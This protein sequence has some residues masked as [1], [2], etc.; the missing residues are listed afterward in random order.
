MAVGSR[1]WAVYVA[2]DHGARF[3]SPEMAVLIPTEQ[4]VPGNDFGYT[5]VADA[6]G[7]IDTMDKRLKPRHVIGT[8]GAGHRS[9][10][11]VADIGANLWTGIAS[12][13]TDTKGTLWTVTG[14]VGESRTRA[15]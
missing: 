10:Q 14:Y 11:I 6:V 12:Q 2:D 15:R 9:K 8:D 1:S 7:S 5:L 13:W 4:T 3:G